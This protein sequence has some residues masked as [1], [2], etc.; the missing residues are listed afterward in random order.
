MI[1]IY[2]TSF[3]HFAV[4]SLL[5]GISGACLSG[6]FNALLYDTLKVSSSEE[7]YEKYL[8]R[9]NALDFIAALIAAILGS[10]LANSF[11]Y[12]LNYWLSVLSMIVA[13]LVTL[14]LTEPIVQSALGKGRQ[15]MAKEV[16]EGVAFFKKRPI[17]CLIAFKAMITGACLNYL[18]EFWQLYLTEIHFPLLWFGI[19]SGVLMMVRVPGNLLAARLL[20]YFKEMTILI[21]VIIT[22]M[23]GF[24]IMGLFSNK[25]GIIGMV[26]A[27]LAYGVV[28]PVVSGYLHH[29]ADSSQRATLESLQSLGERAVSILVGLAF[30]LIVNHMSIFKGY[31][32]L[33]FLCLK[34]L[35]FS[36]ILFI[37]SNI[38][39]RNKTIN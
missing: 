12:E 10:V 24:F 6:S 36:I 33:G 34:L 7:H 17:L 35:I 38:N 32:W 30:G 11:G 13:F 21:W 5:A 8:G 20:G 19:V 14:S 1:I 31:I 39:Y 3:W 25:I 27:S 23:A 15:G 4:V 18:Y 28:E 16:V 22:M 29:R 37:N 2:A 9:I 26:M